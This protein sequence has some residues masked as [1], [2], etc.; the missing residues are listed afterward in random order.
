[1]LEARKSSLEEL[2]IPV[3]LL[4]VLLPQPFYLSASRWLLLAAAHDVGAFAVCDMTDPK[5]LGNIPSS[6]KQQVSMLLIKTPKLSNN[7][8]MYTSAATTK[9]LLQN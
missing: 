7:D 3:L 1:M 9:V 2:A 5:P 8:E 6:H 4:I